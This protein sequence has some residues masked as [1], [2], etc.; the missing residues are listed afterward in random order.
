MILVA[1]KATDI[2]CGI[3]PSPYENKSCGKN[4]HV[5]Y[6]WA[7]W[8]YSPTSKLQVN[9]SAHL[10]SQLLLNSHQWHLPDKGRGLQTAEV[11]TP[12]PRFPSMVFVG[13]HTG[14]IGMLEP[15]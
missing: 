8:S 14:P 6:L 5:V 7:Y 3:I 1:E 13:M 12:L 2:F 11:T 4:A 10:S 15:L 9:Y